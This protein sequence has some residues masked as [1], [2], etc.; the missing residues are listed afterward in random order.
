VCECVAVGLKSFPVCLLIFSV[1]YV[2]VT[3]MSRHTYAAE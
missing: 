3:A 1:I 2:F